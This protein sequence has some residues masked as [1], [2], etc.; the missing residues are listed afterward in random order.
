MLASEKIKISR[1]D[2]IKSG[3]DKTVT[4]Y[5]TKKASTL[6][7]IKQFHSTTGMEKTGYQGKRQV[8][9]CFTHHTTTHF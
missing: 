8:R 7:D 5:G 6:M 3:I 9:A 2:H 4:V 1:T